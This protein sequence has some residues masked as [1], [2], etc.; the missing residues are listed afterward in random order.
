MTEAILALED[1]AVFK[2]ESFG[3]KGHRAGEVV[4][5]TSM[6]GYQQILTDP[7]YAGQILAM[8]YPLIGNYGVNPEDEEAATPALE[9][10]IVYEHALKPSNFRSQGPLD[11]YLQQ[12]SVVG[13][14]G[15]DT[16]ALTKKLRVK[17]TLR[18]VLTSLAEEIEDTDRLIQEAQSLKVPRPDLVAQVSTKKAYTVGEGDNILAL[19]DLGVRKSMLNALLEKG[20]KIHVL[21]WDTSAEEILALNPSGV[22]FSSGPGDP[23]FLTPTIETAKKLQGKLPLGGICLGCQVIGLSLGMGRYKL[24]FGHRGGNQ[25]V[26]DLKTGRLY[27]TSQ[28]HNYALSKDNLPAGVEITHLNLNDDTV[29]GFCHPS[30][31]IMAIQYHPE[32]S[33]GPLDSLYLFDEFAALLS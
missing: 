25:P 5:N 15:I 11:D 4:F 28:N 12:K 6:V 31:Q 2:G 24:K 8:T 21:P 1:G 14:C 20:F 3:A 18:G 29:E 33:P 26:R 23:Q 13:L 17:G 30:L 16:R 9:G 19:I 7:S 22:F 27:I 32:A 10:Y